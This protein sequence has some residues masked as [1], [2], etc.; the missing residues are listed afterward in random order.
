[1]TGVFGDKLASLGATFDEYWATTFYGFSRY[2]YSGGP[3]LFDKNFTICSTQPSI[4]NFQIK[5]NKVRIVNR[6]ILI[7]LDTNPWTSWGIGDGSVDEGQNP[8]FVPS[9][10]VPINYNTMFNVRFPPLFSVGGVSDR[11]CIPTGY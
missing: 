5:D 6:P 8:A 1:M 7:D 2:T 4:A 9:P 3:W 11:S 10:D